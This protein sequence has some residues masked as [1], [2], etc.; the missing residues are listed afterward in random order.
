MII[1]PNNSSITLSILHRLLAGNYSDVGSMQFSTSYNCISTSRLGLQSTPS[2]ICEFAKMPSSVGVYNTLQ[3][4][5]LSRHGNNGFLNGNHPE[6]DMMASMLPMKFQ[7][8]WHYKDCAA[9]EIDRA[10]CEGFLKLF[11]L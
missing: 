2:P 10:L 7:L 3:G 1:L 9:L 6:F 5:V 8:I 11:M 4:D